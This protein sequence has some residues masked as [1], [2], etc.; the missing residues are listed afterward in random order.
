MKSNL[1]DDLEDSFGFES[2]KSEITPFDLF[3]DN[4]IS[5][6]RPIF[7]DIPTSKNES[8][9]VPS[10]I[11]SERKYKLSPLF[12]IIKVK[13]RTILENEIN[14]TLEKMNIT[15]K[16][17]FLN[18]NNHCDEIEKI[19][20]KLKVNKK[21]TKKLL[22]DVNLI[23]QTKRGR[24]KKDDASKG[25]HNKFS[26]DNIIKSIKTKINSSLILFINKIINSIY[27]IDEINQICH[28]LN[29]PEIKFNSTSN[30]VFKNNNYIN[31]VN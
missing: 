28:S 2:Q 1:L 5:S 13:N 11:Y 4:N 22:K 20:N 18:S 14:G 25:C 3:E 8:N 30:E 17:F 26:S 31:R 23:K 16:K 15:E 29:L 27:N 24:K 10:Y 6:L 7:E 19:R 9:Q 12:K 21:R